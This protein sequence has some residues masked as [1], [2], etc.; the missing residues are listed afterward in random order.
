MTMAIPD[1]ST[2]IHIRGTGFEIY[3]LGILFILWIVFWQVGFSNAVN[4][5]DGLD[6]LAAG[7]SVIAFGSFMAIAL[8]RDETTIAVFLLVMAGALLGFLVY[9]KYPA[10]LFMGDTGSLALNGIIATV[11]ILLNESLLLII[12]IVFVIE[13]A[14]VML[15]VASF[16]LTGKT[17]AKMTPIHHHFELVGWSEWKIV[18]VFW[19]AGLIAGGIGV[20][21][22]ER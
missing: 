22:W 9:N 14:S 15:Q 5:T 13:T 18:I 11:S 21:G 4:L 8:M 3:S 2:S 16:K 20:S 19:T 1:I 10:K 17:N 6:G 7:L 12:G